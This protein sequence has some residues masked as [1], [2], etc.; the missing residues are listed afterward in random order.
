[1]RPVDPEPV[2]HLAAEQL[3]ARHAERLGLGVE[4]RVLD[5]AER[6]GDHAAGAGPGGAVEVG[7]D[8]LVLADRLADDAR[9][10]P[11]DHGADAGRAEALRELAPADD[12]AVGGEL[13][14]MVVAPARIAAERLDARYPDARCLHEMFPPP[15]PR[16]TYHLRDQRCARGDRLRAGRALRIDLPPVR[17]KCVR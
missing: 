1:M 7:I 11:M 17:H 16:Y 9:G 15:L 2:A 14:E 6:L 3:V 4:E 13:D 5:G 10:Q 12:A 8:A